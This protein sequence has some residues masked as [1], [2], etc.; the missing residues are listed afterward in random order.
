MIKNI[1]KHIFNLTSIVRLFEILSERKT[2]S[3]VPHGVDFNIDLKYHLP[4]YELSVIF[5]VGAN[6]GQSAIKFRKDYP[7]SDI[8]SFEAV[9]ST[10][11]TL[12]S[13]VKEINVHCYNY[14]L[15]NEN[16][17]EKITLSEKNEFNRIIKSEKTNSNNQT[18]DIAIKKLD[19]LWGNKFQNI[20]MI[21]LLKIDT[22]GFDLEVL[23]GAENLI[24]NHKI[25]FIE[26]ETGMNSSNLDHIFITDFY[27]FLN[28]YNYLLFGVYE[29]ILDF[30]LK[31]PVLRRSNVVFISP[32]V[33]NKQQNIDKA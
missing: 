1:I 33:Y 19:Y 11:D 5:D 10:F 25:D 30:K 29:Q 7:K 20:E 13:K 32:N 3:K 12:K 15:G 22:E 27:K 23:K 17:I 26:I 18:E 28:P 31:K 14:A 8:H 24:S 4:N 6:V 2:Y 9:N 16:K 21:S